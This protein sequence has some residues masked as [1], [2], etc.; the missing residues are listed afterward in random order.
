MRKIARF[1]LFLFLF[2]LFVA[3]DEERQLWNTAFQKEDPQTAQTPKPARRRYKSATPEIATPAS[4]PATVVGVTIW[5]LA[6]SGSAGQGARLL[7]HEG[8][9]NVEWVAQ[10]VDSGKSLTEGSHVRL[11]VESGKKGFL[12]VI[13]REKY[14]DGSTGEPYLIFPTSRLS[15]ANNTVRTG[16]VV[17]V[18]SQDDSP[19][20]FTL[21][22]SRSD[23]V[24]EVLS[25][26]VAPSEIPDLKIGREPLKLSAELVADWEK[27]YSKKAGVLELEGGAGQAWTEAEK[28]AGTGSRSLGGGDPLPQTLYF[29]P[30]SRS[31]APLMVNVPLQIKRED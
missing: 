22:R 24:A 15:G 20:Y 6:P 14:A 19:P 29:N 16:V 12:Y 1:A 18:P 7:V 8:T 4:A 11:S 27:Q 17:E 28:Q 5:Q 21:K 9:Q 30:D 13:D 25:V 31:E 3:A 26:L 10:R 23:H 2:A